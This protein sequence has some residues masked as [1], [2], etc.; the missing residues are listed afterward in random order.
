MGCSN[1]DKEDFK[2][3]CGESLASLIHN[4]A[5]RI[6]RYIAYQQKWENE[7]ERHYPLVRPVFED[8]LIIKRFSFND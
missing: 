4:N 1:V 7:I 6:N 2:F 8:G 3:E 5:D